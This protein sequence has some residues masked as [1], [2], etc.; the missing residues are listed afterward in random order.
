MSLRRSLCYNAINSTCVKLQVGKKHTPVEFR[1]SVDSRDR[2]IQKVDFGS[3]F[4]PA[5]LRNYNFLNN[6]IIFQHYQVHL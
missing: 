4:V 1:K 3:R 2:V 5:Y 6:Y